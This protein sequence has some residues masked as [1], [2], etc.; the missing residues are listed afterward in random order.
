MRGSTKDPLPM[1]LPANANAPCP[2]AILCH[3]PWRCHAAVASA[4]HLVLNMRILPEGMYK[5]YTAISGG[6]HLRTEL[7]QPHTNS[8]TSGWNGLGAR[9]LRFRTPPIQWRTRIQQ[10]SPLTRGLLVT[11]LFLHMLIAIEFIQLS[12]SRHPTRMELLSWEN[13][14]WCRWEGV[15]WSGWEDGIGSYRTA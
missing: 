12:I 4:N 6:N 2:K 3:C 15:E 8:P 7:R 13:V 11:R 1:A 10:W 5:Y 9:K 14:E